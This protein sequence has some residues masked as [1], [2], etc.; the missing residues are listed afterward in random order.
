MF[1]SDDLH[2]DQLVKSHINDLLRRGVQKGKDVFDLLRAATY[3][4]KKFYNLETGLLQPGDPADFVRVKNL[5]EFE[6]RET[7]INGERVFNQKGINFAAGESEAPNYFVK[8]RM[9]EH[10]LKVP[11]KGK[12]VKVIQ[13]LDGELWTNT[14]IARPNS[15]KGY[16]ESDTEEDILKLVVQ[17]RYKKEKPAIGFINNMGLKYGGMISTIAHDSHN[18]ICTATHDKIILELLGWINNNRGGIAFS[19]GKKIYGLPLPV[20]G[21]LSDQSAYEVAKTYHEL[22]NKVKQAG[23]DLK[24]PF[25]TLSFMALLVIPELKLSNKGLFEVN[26]FRISDLYV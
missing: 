17:N 6:V 9:E 19:D 1:C 24:A 14:L 4:P 5:K 16:L 26:Q 3:N 23:S 15:I 20:A 2:P 25:M 18:I 7:Y 11:D 22:E 10:D 12:S 13:V 21:L 8:N